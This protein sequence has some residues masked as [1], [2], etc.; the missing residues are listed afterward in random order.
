MGGA[1][2]AV[3][4][5]QTQAPSTALG[6]VQRG[7]RADGGQ[8][9]GGRGL[10]ARATGAAA[11]HQQQARRAAVPQRRLGPGG[12]SPH[13]QDG[14]RWPVGLQSR[15]RPCEVI[16]GYLD[17]RR[18]YFLPVVAARGVEVVDRQLEAAAQPRRLVALG[19]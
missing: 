13:Q 15:Q 14:R 6:F 8:A 16:G 10:E 12:V 2:L 5:Q 17:D 18:L 4:G 11:L 7:V 1:K 9:G 19:P 3:G